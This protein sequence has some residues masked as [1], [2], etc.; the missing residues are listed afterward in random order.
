MLNY[1]IR[2]ILIMI[3]TLIG[4][5]IMVFLIA[6]FAPGRPGT[7]AFGEGGQMDAEGQKK[8]RE[9]YEERYGLDLPLYQQY[10]RWWRGMFSAKTEARA[11]HDASELEPLYTWREPRV[12]RYTVDRST[13]Q[14][15]LLKS[16]EPADE[17]LLQ[18]DSS[19][20]TRVA[21]TEQ[22]RLL[23]EDPAY[24]VPRHVFAAAE[25]VPIE[26]L[27]EELLT[28]ATESHQ[29]DV[30][31]DAWWRTGQKVYLHPEETNPD[32]PKRLVYE[33]DS[34]WY[35]ITPTRA[36]NRWQVF[37][38]DDPSFK[39]KVPGR[40]YEQLTSV[41][42][43]RP[44]P[45]HVEVVGTVSKIDG[46][47]Y[48]PANLTRAQVNTNAT[49]EAWVWLEQNGWPVFVA[50]EPI[51]QK[52]YQ[53][54]SGQW[55]RLIGE[56]RV[57]EPDYATWKQANSDFIA[58][59]PEAMKSSLPN[60]REGHIA[61]RHVIMTGDATPMDEAPSE[62]EIRRYSHEVR[63]PAL[64]LGYSLTT[65]TTVI[66]E[67]KTRLPVTLGINI[68]AFPIIY[69]IAI[70]TGMLMALKRGKGFDQGSNVVLLALWSV[71]VV[72]TATLAIGYLA[73]GG[74]GL[75]WF[76][77]G[78]L[79]SADY[80]SLPFWGKIQDR[81]HHL[82]LPIATIVYGGFAYLAK[83]MRA[84]MLENFTMDYVRAARAKGVSKRDIVLK[85][86]L[87]NSLIPIITIFATILPALIAGSVIL[88]KI[89]NIEGMGLFAFRA[90]TN[91]DYDVV[92]SLALIFG[93]LNL[94][95]LLLAD[96]CY[97]IV[98]PRITYK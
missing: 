4:I 59:V 2:R 93:V 3:P 53:D 56:N 58:R 91:R 26:S 74:K 9:W 30:T 44:I 11:W 97:A 5:T 28:P 25:I 87:R 89:Y 36:P 34:A 45:R 86:V 27:P 12:E 55:L 62:R 24:P 19:F 69:I 63:V 8:L 94:L 18:S 33:R 92:Q 77:T 29:I 1:I 40:V 31:A 47:D 70:P 43:E 67:I 54:E 17:A 57:V 78:G 16:Y 98:D 88:E 72:L 39:S 48:D 71:P 80:D 95:S 37:G 96:I 52:F 61:P 35:E 84:A 73:E 68:L 83:Q 64:T 32:D 75:Q 15:Y 38:Q 51:A 41:Q 85:H 60:E 46:A 14:W 42:D 79:T 50:E 65:H 66:S 21:D 23:T 76:P 81:I 49:I 13:G 10:F 90:V 6:R 20:L 7:G 22:T 82:I